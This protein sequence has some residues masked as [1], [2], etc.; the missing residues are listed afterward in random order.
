MATFTKRISAKGEVT[1]K[2]EVRVHSGK[3]VAARRTKT[4]KTMKEAKAWARRVEV[5]LRQPINSLLPE[6]T[7]QSLINR[8]IDA[9]DKVSPMGRTRRETLLRMG[10][11]QFFDFQAAELTGKHLIDYCTMRRNERVSPSTVMSDVVCLRGPF[12]DAKPLLDICLDDKVFEEHMP[13]LR[14]L[15][16]VRTPNVRNRRPESVEIDRLMAA[17]RKRLEHSAA[18][19]PMADIVEFAIASCMRQG[20]IVNL[21]WVDLDE[22]ARTIIV[23]ERKNPTRKLDQV[24]PLLPNAYEVI[25]RQPKIDQ[26]I[27][28]YDGRSVCAAFTRVCQQL[29]I[30]DLRFHDLRR[31]GIT[32]LLELGMSIP[33]VASVSGH[34][35][36][37]ILTRVYT[38]ISPKHMQNRWASLQKESVP[39]D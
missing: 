26:R 14:R 28:P 22:E 29:G 1:Y 25:K 9:M 24:V 18:V 4:F 33:E 31:E 30:V 6:I 38:A 21:R 13:V 2:T 5:Q 39:S 17:F 15:G 3:K 12:R 37:D 32:R 27:F 35:D 34:L 16:L 23:H 36:V 11:L 20:E 8:Y 7:V 10:R 19:L